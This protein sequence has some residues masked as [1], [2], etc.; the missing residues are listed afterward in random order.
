MCAFYNDSV[1]KN[2]LPPHNHTNKHAIW[3]HKMFRNTS[4]EPVLIGTVSSGVVAL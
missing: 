2:I 3:I 1:A 4:T